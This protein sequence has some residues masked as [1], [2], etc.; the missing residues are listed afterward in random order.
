[1]QKWWKV[2]KDD[3]MGFV[4]SSIL[5]QVST[6]SSE[7]IPN[8]S[9]SLSPMRPRSVSKLSISRMSMLSPAELEN[10][11]TRQQSLDDRYVCY[12]AIE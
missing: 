7:A 4:P 10:V 11:E 1:M 5:M 8:P 2:A 9:A 3:K 6:D 12:N